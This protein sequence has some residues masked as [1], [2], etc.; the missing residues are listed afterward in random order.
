[1][2]DNILER[3]KALFSF[4]KERRLIVYGDIHGCINEL[5]ELRKKIKPTKNDIEICAGD[6]ITKGYDSIGV[7]EFLIK[8]N[9][10]AVLGN[11]EDKI[12]RFMEHERSIKKNPMKLNEN[13]KNI[14]KK[15]KDKHLIYLKSLPVFYRYGDITVVHGGIQNH[16]SLN[17]LTP[18]AIQMV[19][20]LRNVDKNGNFVAKGKEDK[21]SSFWADVYDG[22]EG[23]VIHGHR[24]D[25]KVNYHPHAIG[26]DTG[27]VYGN[28]LT[29]IVMKSKSDYEIVQQDGYKKI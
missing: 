17:D 9:I 8:N 26:I 14:I 15:F 6:M 3:L 1:M 18:H 2:L 10:K 23:F 4:Q 19:L 13:E 5:K 16:T 28:K 7:L 27:C 29:A 21:N 11:H 25:K 24:W 22:H 20:R 12:L